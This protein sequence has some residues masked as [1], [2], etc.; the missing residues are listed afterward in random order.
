MKPEFD[1]VKSCELCGASIYPEML[2]EGKADRFGGQLLCP[3][4]LRERR[5]GARELAP[6]TA[7]ALASAN[8]EVAGSAVA[9][10]AGAPSRQVRFNA[11]ITRD[12]AGADHHH[13]RR[14]LDPRS[15]FATRCRTFHCKLSEASF[16]HLNHQVN[17]WVDAHDDVEVK[18]ATSSVGIL[19]GKHADPHLIITVFY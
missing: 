2:N 4:C 1:G 17:E 9:A 6:A 5:E 11:G 12:S 10:D 18:F 15:A 16:A 3:H 8:A 13:Y 19:E 7:A 14:A